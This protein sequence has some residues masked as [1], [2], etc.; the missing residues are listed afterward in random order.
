M[1][2]YNLYEITDS[3]VLYDKNPP[4]FMIYVISI[5]LIL[6]IGFTYWSIKSVKTYIVKGQGIVT[7]ENKYNIMPKV[8]GEI[9]DVFIKEGKE[10]KAGETLV[11]LKPVESNIQIEQIDSQVAV[12]DKRIELLSRAENDANN[13]RNS[14]MKQ[15]QRNQSFIKSYVIYIYNRKNLR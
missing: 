1:G 2:T 8:S 15:I 13:G 3:R 6:L 11:T 12:I 7:T 4:R 9:K 14:L 10:V 5:V